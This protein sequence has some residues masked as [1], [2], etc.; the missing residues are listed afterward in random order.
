MIDQ[1]A[2]VTHNCQNQSE[3]LTTSG[4]RTVANPEHV[5]IVKQGSVILQEWRDNNS[6]K[7]LELSGAD[8]AQLN[9]ENCNLSKADLTYAK[10]SEGYLDQC[11]LHQ[12][13]LSDS[14]LKFTKLGSAHLVEANLTRADMFRCELVSSDLQATN[15]SEANLQ[16]AYLVDSNLKNANLKHANLRSANLKGVI[17]Y[18]TNLIQADLSNAC[19][20]ETLWANLDLSETIGLESVEH[21]KPSSIDVGTLLKSKGF[22]PVIFLR[23]CGLPEDFISAIPTLF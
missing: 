19:I 11:N 20:G 3:H 8:L 9:L 15:L 2:S 4:E 6:G 18:G 16:R 10:L 14:D 13:N 23:G 21:D 12:A 22:L 5:E 17:F 7:T 1:S